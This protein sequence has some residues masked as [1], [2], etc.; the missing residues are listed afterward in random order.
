MPWLLRY[1]VTAAQLHSTAKHVYDTQFEHH[2]AACCSTAYCDVSQVGARA[3]ARAGVRLP[4]DCG[5]FQHLP[6]YSSTLHGI[7]DYSMRPPCLRFTSTIS[8]TPLILGCTS[9]IISDSAGSQRQGGELG[10]AVPNSIKPPHPRSQIALNPNP[11]SSFYLLP[12]FL[13]CCGTTLVPPV[14]NLHPATLHTMPRPKRTHTTR[15]SG[16]ALARSKVSNPSRIA[17]PFG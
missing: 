11:L 10:T 16:M 13:D 7:P 9:V 15:V 1:D 4:P 3:G 14:I 12:T 6:Q 5:R 8:P 17:G 2:V